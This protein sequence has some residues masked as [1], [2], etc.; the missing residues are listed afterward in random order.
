MPLGNIVYL[1]T[2][3]PEKMHFYDHHEEPRTITDPTTRGPVIR[4][5]LVMEVDMHNDRPAA[6]TFST[7]A[8]VLYNKLSPY[9][10]DKSY[11]N[12]DFIITAVGESF[13]RTYSLKALPRP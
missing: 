4:N 2:G 13:R 12:Y 5:T 8:D 9:L 1:T 7:M 11:R 10:P 6:A 3:I